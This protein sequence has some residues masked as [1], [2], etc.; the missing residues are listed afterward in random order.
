[1]SYARLILSACSK[2]PLPQGTTKALPPRYA[3]TPLVQHYLNNVFILLP[4]FDEA[5]FYASLDTVYSKDTRPA[6]PLDHWVVRM[7]LAIASASMSE[8]RGDQYYL[9]GER[10]EATT[11]LL[12]PARIELTA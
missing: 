10:Y 9:E 11:V 2:D 7:V 12:F 6:E 5:S 1:M 4:V 3:A 8:Q